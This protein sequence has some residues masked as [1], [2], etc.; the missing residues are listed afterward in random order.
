[1]LIVS[2]HPNTRKMIGAIFNANNTSLKVY[3]MSH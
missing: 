3:V 2:E 1:M